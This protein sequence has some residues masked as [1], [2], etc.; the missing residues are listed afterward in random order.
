MT[1]WALLLLASVLLATPG[2]TFCGLSPEDHDLDMADRCQ[3]E[4]F[5]RML[6]QETPQED[7]PFTLCGICMCIVSWVKNCLGFNLIQKV[8][9]KVAGLLCSACPL[10]ENICK[11]W[12]TSFLDKITSTL[13][14]MEPSRHICV[15][16]GMCCPY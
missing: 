2:L 15:F 3:D 14:H 9:E 6:A 10:V 7:R 4:K 12:I 16:L 11:A 8:I 13:L 5:F 1:S